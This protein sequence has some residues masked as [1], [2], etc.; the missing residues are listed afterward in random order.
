LSQALPRLRVNLF[1][2]REM[3]AT[4]AVFLAD[5]TDGSHYGPRSGCKADI[6]E[7]P[8]VLLEFSPALLWLYGVW[9]CH[10]E[11]VPLLQLAWAF[12]GNSIPKLRQNFTVRCRIHISTTLQKIC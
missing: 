2:I 8:A 5:Q 3:F 12:S 10:D 11:A 4:K 1:V 6:Q 9:H 7:V